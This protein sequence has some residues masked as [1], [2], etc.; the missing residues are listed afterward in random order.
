MAEPDV[1]ETQPSTINGKEL[2]LIGLSRSGTHAITHWIKQ[3]ANGR[4]CFLNCAEGKTNPFHSARPMENGKV[5][6]VNYDNF[7]IQRERESRLSEKDFLIYS[8]EDSFLGHA[9]SDTFEQWH[10]QWVGASR[11]RL[12]VLVLRDPFNLFASRLKRPGGMVQPEIAIRIWQQHARQ[13]WRVRALKQRPVLIAFNH[14]LADRDYRRVV[15]RRLGLTFTDAGKDH[16]PGVFGGSSFDGRA[17]DGR[18]HEMRV[19]ERWRWFID[20][21]R[22]RSL[23]DELTLELSRGIFGEL[24]PEMMLSETQASETR[25]S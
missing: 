17:Y 4:I 5:Y 18:A 13:W 6:W 14:W 12:D 21:P 11:E 3:Q 8:Y 25:S 23:F 20:D 24:G 9:C 2:R 10:D 7:D 1:T 16:V 22:Y 19:L 15:A